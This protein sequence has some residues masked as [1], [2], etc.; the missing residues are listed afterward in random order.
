[1]IDDFPKRFTDDSTKCLKLLISHANYEYL[2]D[3]LF[4][5]D[6]MRHNYFFFF[7]STNNKLKKKV[8]EKI[9]VVFD[10]RALYFFI[11]SASSTH[12]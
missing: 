2:I 4:F 3:L 9:S 6:W 7:Q 1:M 5:I 8:W 12:V 10:T 11:L